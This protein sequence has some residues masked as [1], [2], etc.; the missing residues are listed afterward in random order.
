MAGEDDPE[1][2]DPDSDT[3]NYQETG[4]QLPVFCVSSRGYQHQCGI[5]VQKNKAYPGFRTL[6]DTQIP[7]LK[8]HARDIVREMRI[9][10]C[11]DFLGSLAHCLTSLKLQVVLAD[12]PLK[13]ADNLK[14]K[15]LEF[16]DQSLEKL[17]K[18]SAKSRDWAGS[19]IPIHRAVANQTYP[20]RISKS[21]SPHPFN[22]CARP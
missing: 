13:M 4:D 5:V 3:K 15:E 21:L 12:K 1:S 9:S 22:L 20:H 18:V 10:G 16:L 6:E 19:S 14:A 7:Q 2:F 17:R 8:A 11:Q